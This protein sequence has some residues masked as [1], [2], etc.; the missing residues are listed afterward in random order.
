MW[1]I[2]NETVNMGKIRDKAILFVLSMGFI[3]V[4]MALIAIPL[5]LLF[6]IPF[7]DFAWYELAY[8]PFMVYLAWATFTLTALFGEPETGL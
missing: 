8:G 4:L 3:T 1:T 6:P 5:H 2:Q 7:N